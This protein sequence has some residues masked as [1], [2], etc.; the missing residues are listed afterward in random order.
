MLSLALLPPLRQIL[1]A[2]AAAS[3]AASFFASLAPDPWFLAQIQMVESGSCN[4]TLISKG[5]GSVSHHDHTRKDSPKQE[6]GLDADHPSKTTQL[7]LTI[8]DPSPR[9]K[10][11]R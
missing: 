2:A 1:E 10:T 6:G 11:N 7:I 3:G 9:I 4:P 5:W 8:I